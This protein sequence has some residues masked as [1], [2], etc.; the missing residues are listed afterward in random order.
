M[1]GRLV[2]LYMEAGASCV[3][4]LYLFRGGEIGIEKY[5]AMI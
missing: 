2:C 3:R 5:E 1:Y 4:C